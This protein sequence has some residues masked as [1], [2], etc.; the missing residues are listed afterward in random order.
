[1]V[2]DGLKDGPGAAGESDR[3]VEKRGAAS[4]FDWTHMAS[5]NSEGGHIEGETYLG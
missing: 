2:V 5:V 1:M 4:S 3:S